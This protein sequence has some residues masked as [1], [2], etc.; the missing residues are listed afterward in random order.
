MSP[1]K[2]EVPPAIKREP[3]GLKDFL[4]ELR[5]KRIIEIWRGL[6]GAAG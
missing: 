2:R 1:P 4:L 3:S 5:K 6:S